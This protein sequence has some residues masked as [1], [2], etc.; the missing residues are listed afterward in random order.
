M[1]VSTTSLITAYKE[2][3]NTATAT[4]QDAID[5]AELEIDDG[6]LGDQYDNAVLLLAC[7]YASISHHGLDMRLEKDDKKTTYYNDYER[8]MRRAG[9]S[10]RMLG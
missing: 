1:A 2:F 4:L 3:Q 6:V 8:L 7:H 9:A 10:W 5:R